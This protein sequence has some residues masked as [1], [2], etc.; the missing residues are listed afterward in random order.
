M[1]QT[2]LSVGFSCLDGV[3][4]TEI[5]P[6]QN[7]LKGQYVTLGCNSVFFWVQVQL[8]LPHLHS[9]N[10]LVPNQY[11]CIVL[12]FLKSVLMG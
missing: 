5:K 3:L 1:L 10:P 11:Y 9:L 12:Y 7:N 2:D 8:P 6:T 4:N